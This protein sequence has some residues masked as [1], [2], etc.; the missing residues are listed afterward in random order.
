MLVSR[1]VSAFSE[2]L[3]GSIAELLG[4]ATGFLFDVAPQTREGVEVR[5]LV[6]KVQ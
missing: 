5:Y 3:A 4:K 2:K 6:F 1:I